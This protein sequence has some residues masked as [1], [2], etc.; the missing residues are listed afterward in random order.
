MSIKSFFNGLAEKREEKRKYKALA[1]AIRANDVAGVKQALANGAD[2]GYFPGNTRKLPLSLAIQTGNGEIA[3]LLLKGDRGMSTVFLWYYDFRCLNKTNDIEKQVYF[4]PSFLY[5]AIEQKKEDVAL[6]L[7]RYPMVDV[8]NS[9]ELMTT[10]ARNLPRTS[11]CYDQLK[12]PLDFARAQGL[13]RVAEAI[14]EKLKPIIARRAE[15]EAADLAAKAGAK[16]AEA[17]KL[18]READLLQPKPPQQKPGFSL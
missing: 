3:E 16:R 2:A 9:G 18:L 5:A 10:R 1:A 6:A 13:T 4:L 8:E 17:E 11:P 7:V 15:Q 14:E 12:K